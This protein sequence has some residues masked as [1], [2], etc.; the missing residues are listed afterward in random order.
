[1]FHGHLSLANGA[2][3]LEGFVHA[4][5]TYTYFG[6]FPSIIRI[7]I[8]LVTSSLDGKLTATS[9]LLAW[10]LTGLFAA[11]CCCGESGSSFVAIPLWGEP[12]PRHSGS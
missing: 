5:R 7:P 2:L 10:L 4:G 11:R 3:G 6:L 9:I 12:K 1:M 8:L